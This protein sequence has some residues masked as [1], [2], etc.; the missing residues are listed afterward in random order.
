MG[1]EDAVR[2]QEKNDT[3]N[4]V[5]DLYSRICVRGTECH[6]EIDENASVTVRCT[7]Q[8]KQN[9]VVR[10]I[11]MENSNAIAEKPLVTFHEIRTRN[12]IILEIKTRTYLQWRR[13]WHRG[14]VGCS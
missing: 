8:A 2:G 9:V 14:L 7:V 12:D 13:V 1:S 6:F 11:S 4:C 10:D 5:V 3:Y